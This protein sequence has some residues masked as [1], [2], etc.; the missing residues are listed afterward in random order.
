[1]AAGRSVGIAGGR[2]LPAAPG[3]AGLQ[4]VEIGEDAA[5]MQASSGGWNTPATVSRV[6]VSPP[7]SCAGPRLRCR[8]PARRSRRWRGSRQGTRRRSPADGIE[9]G[10]ARRRD[11][12]EGA[13]DQD[14]HHL[15]AI[16]LHAQ[17]IDHDEAGTGPDEALEI[18]PGMGQQHQ[19]QKLDQ[20]SV[21]PATSPT[22]T[23]ARKSYTWR[24]SR[25]AS[26]RAG[27]GP[28]RP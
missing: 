20:G 22:R 1:M 7:R 23:Q 2:G 26:G 14:A 28:R 9:G 3:P 4:A 15:E 6:P 8:S 13:V 25:S 16:E 18:R 19:P 10:A 17:G 24:A 11:G 12:G 21:Q 5:E 27:S